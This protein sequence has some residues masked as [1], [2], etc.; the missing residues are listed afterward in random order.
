MDLRASDF[1]TYYQPGKCDLRVYLRHRGLEEA[2]A[3]PF[4]EVLLRLGER[5]EKAHLATFPEV[6]DLSSVPRQQ[7]AELTLEAMARKAPVIYQGTF[8]A[9]TRP[10]GEACDIVGDPDFLILAADGR[11]VV[12]DS[13]ISRRITED[14]H[15]EILRQLGLYGWLYSQT[16]GEPPAA[17]QV[18]CGTG[19]IVEVEYDGGKTALADLGHIVEVRRSPSEPY[20]PVGWSKCGACGYNGICWTRAEKNRDVALVQGVDQGLAIGLRQIGVNTVSDL[21]AKFEAERLAEFPRPWGKKTQRVGKKAESIMLMAEAMASGKEILIAS[22]A[23]PSHA[24]YVM[25]DLEGMPPHL[26]ETGKIYLWGTQVF[27]QRPGEYV[28]AV[29]DFG[30]DGDRRAWETFLKSAEQIFQAHGDIPFVHWAT[31]E[32]TQVKEYI[33][34]FGDRDGIAARVKDNLLDLLPIT[35]KSLALPLPSYSLKVIEKYVGFER[36]QEEY[37]GDWSMAKYIEATETEDEQLRDEV[38]GQI[39]TYNEED[40]AATWAVLK[41]LKSKA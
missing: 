12:N 16:T 32:K 3:S 18:H 25:F 10:S 13:K 31:Y 27:G 17:L 40:L 1:Y 22:P 34:R 11:Y 36:S 19:E 14:D 7:R 5:H 26:D 37:G 28:A 24:N 4:E 38:M 6:V 35:Q 21:L 8:C 9:T 15:P 29:A 20:S 23:L 33:K 2:P 39:L 41:W 30:E